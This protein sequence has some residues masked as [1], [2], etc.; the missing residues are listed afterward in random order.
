M[1]LSVCLQS[2]TREAEVSKTPKKQKKGLT[3]KKWLK[4]STPSR[5]LQSPAG[6]TAVRSTNFV[7]VAALPIT[8]KSVTK[9]HFSLDRVCPSVWSN[10]W[11]NQAKCGTHRS[12]SFFRTEISEESHIKVCVVQKRT[13]CLTEYWILV[14]VGSVQFTFARN[15]SFEAKM[16]D[17][18]FSHWKGIFGEFVSKPQSAKSCHH[19]CHSWTHGKSIVSNGRKIVFLVFSDHIWRRQWLR[20]MAQTLVC[21]EKSHIVLLEVSWWRKDQGNILPS[22]MQKNLLPITFVLGCARL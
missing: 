16:P 21:V 2:V 19:K 9:T 8:I 10:N 12:V 5:G 13:P 11:W 18:E 14:F 17:G 6:P 15:D 7:L 1:Q 3:P 20:S 4:G 22:E